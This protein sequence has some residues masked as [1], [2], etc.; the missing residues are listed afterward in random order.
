MSKNSKLKT[1]FADLEIRAAPPID[2]RQHQGQRP[3]SGNLHARCRPHQQVRRQRSAQVQ[4]LDPLEEGQALGRPRPGRLRTELQHG[5]GKGWLWIWIGKAV[6]ATKDLLR[7]KI[8]GPPRRHS[9]GNRGW[10][11]YLTKYS[12][13]SM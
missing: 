3:R 10:R 12:E 2:P 11:N 8:F 6:E 5:F 4:P 7:A 13:F 9:K 1:R